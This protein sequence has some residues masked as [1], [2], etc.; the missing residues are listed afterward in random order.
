MSTFE[1]LRVVEHPQWVEVWLN[2]PAARN[3]MSFQMVEELRALFSS[4]GD[5]TQAVVLRGSGGHFC[6][7]GDVKDM[8]T[9]LTQ[10]APEGLEDAGSKTLDRDPL[11][12]ANRKFGEMLSELQRCPQVLIV[13][14]EG[15]VMGGGFGL[16]CI[17]DV[18]FALPSARFALPEVTLGITPAQIAPFVVTRVGLTQARRLAL[19]GRRFKAREALSLGIVHEVC[20]DEEALSRAL[21]E[22]L[23]AISACAPQARIATKALLHEV[24]AQ[25]LDATLDRAA[26]GFAHAARNGEGMAGMMAFISKTPPAWKTAWGE[27]SV[28]STEARS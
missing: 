6:A 21:E 10:P 26:L 28:P 9:V 15:S 27:V 20:E 4:L 25:D 11:A 24:V 16:A 17:S 18:A 12:S 5:D 2:R 13:A 23:T 7:G 1:T 19:T 3:A 22:T 14:L 8:R